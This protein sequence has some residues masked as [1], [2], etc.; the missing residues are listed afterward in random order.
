M[1]ELLY[2]IILLN[3]AGSV[4]VAAI[5]YL[6]NR[7]QPPG[8]LVGLA[9][10]VYACWL[11]SFAQYLRPHAPA[12]ALIWA[13]LTLTFGILDTPLFLHL[14]CALV[15]QTR[16]WRWWI[17]ASYLTGVF[18]VWLLWDGHLVTGLRST[19][20]LHHYVSYSRSWY[21]WLGLHIVGWQWFGVVILVRNAWRATGYKRT[22]LMYFIVAWLV[23]FFAG[24]SIIIPIEYD[25]QILP[26]GFF[27][28]PVMLGLLGYAMAKGRLTDFNLVIARLLLYLLTLVII[29]SVGLIFV[30][31]MALVAPGFMNTPQILFTLALV[32]AI[33]FAMTLFLPRAERMEQE[34]MF[35]GRFGYQDA[36]SGLVKE[37]SHLASLDQVFATAVARIQAEMQLTRA[38]ILLQNPISGA[39]E[40]Q[41]ESGMSSFEKSDPF[42]LRA[43]SAVV[44]WLE[45]HND[46]LVRDELPRREGANNLQQLG[47]E[48]AQLQVVVC[49]P[50]ALE[51]RLHGVLCLG[52]KLNREMYYA[53]DLCVLE[54]LA[55]ELALAIRYR[56]LEEQM[57]H[58]NKL[59]EL[60]TIAAGVA[61]EIRNP[62]ASIR[63]F[64]QLLPDKM[65]DPEFQTDF[66]QRVLK[67]VERI[68]NVIQSMLAFS[69]P[70]TVNIAE[71]PSVDLVDEAVLLVQPHLK[72]KRVELTLQFHEKPTL[73]VDKQ[74][75][76]QVLVNLLNNAADA[77]AEGG[78]IRI[79]T[80]V[81]KMDGLD[82]RG[83]QAFAVIE[84][85][86]NG[87]GISPA[88]RNRLFD[89]FFTTKKDGTGLGLSISQKIVRDHGG[90][91]TVSSIEGKGTSFQVNLPI[92]PFSDKN[93]K[94]ESMAGMK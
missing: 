32:V 52:E 68:T 91:I 56:H 34:R 42:H 82:S 1:N 90:I 88:A 79:A 77:L 51:R 21:P 92:E 85:T 36:L 11:A 5:T 72:R 2:A 37:V 55:A 24:N 31:G 60:G 33:G 41:V 53:S 54:T 7:H 89:P 64:A 58:Q 62:L 59:V 76:L 74:Q 6:R 61:H 93:V 65:H 47:A 30:G 44:R 49:V 3:A 18:F 39:Y 80:G 73:R 4:I 94:A 19:L 69:R 48:L 71:Y 86:D 63:T 87:A 45:K 78:R 15:G 16:R 27:L 20:Y 29:A 28:L 81:R 8:V 57:M 66:C 12:T 75:I 22:Q 14:F 23:A 83:S 13:K 50:M 38:L 84:V 40:L 67:D 43:D 10:L 35:R 26:F 46:L 70:G 17:G 25:L 9:M